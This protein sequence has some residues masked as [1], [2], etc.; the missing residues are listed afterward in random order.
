MKEVKFNRIIPVMI[1]LVLVMTIILFLKRESP[2]GL[3]F[4]AA[5]NLFFMGLTAIICSLGLYLYRKKSTILRAIAFIPFSLSGTLCLF[6][7]LAIFD[8]RI[9]LPMTS[10]DELSAI[11]LKEDLD[12]FKVKLKEHPGYNPLIDSIVH[13][14]IDP[15]YNNHENINR[16]EFIGQIIETIGLFKDGHSFLPPFQVYNRSRYLPLA[17]H[18]FDDGYYILKTSDE[19]AELK[20]KKIL[21]IN[22]KSIESIF[23]DVN[24]LTGPE[25][26]WNARSRLNLYLLSVNTLQGL[27]ILPND[28][29]A[30]I[31]YQ[32]EDNTKHSLKVLSTPFVNWVFWAFKPDSNNWPVLNNLR[33]PNFSLNL[34][35]GEIELK[36][37]LIE[38]ISDKE[39]FSNLAVEMDSILKTNIVNRIVIDLR[40]NTGGNN[41][42]YQPLIATL[43]RYP[44]IN[45]KEC[46]F[47]L[48]SRNTFSA[49][50]NFV[51]DLKFETNATLI[52]EPTGAGANHFGDAD[53]IQLPNSGV[54]FFLSTK[55]W[56]SRDSL[57]QRNLISPDIPV[58]FYFKD[59]IRNND[60]WWNEVNSVSKN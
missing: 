45:Q 57:D 30:M 52:G 50:I 42:L 43:R 28:T 55:Q 48:I 9:I 8:Y 23:E 5:L 27:N 56:K 26:I 20:N 13:K 11:E 59:Y 29:G 41:Q 32:E 47:I 10:A 24:Q 35:G 7:I 37:N 1:G 60:P 18:Y 53:L 40:N 49:G 3:I 44:K 25:N 51:D 16:N 6:F 38:N 34:K 2:F 36:I 54:F 21:K 17:C 15:L 4:F 31:T 22:N 33:K 12:F 19:Y 14:K 39:T 46:L 58:K